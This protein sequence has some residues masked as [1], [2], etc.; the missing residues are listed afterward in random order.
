MSVPELLWD[1]DGVRR[2]TRR[3]VG[4]SGPKGYGGGEVVLLSFSACDFHFFLS[5]KMMKTQRSNPN[6]RLPPATRN[7]GRGMG[8]DPC[9][10]ARTLVASVELPY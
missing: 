7:V 5:L 8:E 6:A 9:T 1:P 10:G 4:F 3:K 2:G